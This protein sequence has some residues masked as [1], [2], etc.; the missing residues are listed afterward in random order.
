MIPSGNAVIIRR[1]IVLICISLSIIFVLAG[2][3]VRYLLAPALPVPD[4]REA[5]AVIDFTIGHSVFLV[6][7]KIFSLPFGAHAGGM[8]CL[9]ALAGL[10]LHALLKNKMWKP[11]AN[12]SIKRLFLWGLVF[13][14]LAYG[15][16][17][18]WIPSVPSAVPAD[19]FACIGSLHA[20]RYVNIALYMLNHNA[21]PALQ[22]NI[23][24][25]L[26][27]VIPSIMGFDHLFFSLQ[28]WL[29]ISLA[30]LAL[31]LFG[32]FRDF[33][34]K[35][36]FLFMGVA[37]VFLGNTALYPYH[38]LNIDSGSPFIINGY[39]DSI[40]SLTSL[41][42]VVWLLLKAMAAPP[43]SASAS[44]KSGMLFGIIGAAW[45]LYAPQNVL[46]MLVAF[47]FFFFLY[48]AKK[49]D[50]DEFKT[51]AVFVLSLILAA[52]LAIKAGFGG[53]LAPPSLVDKP[54]IAGLLDMRDRG[55][56]FLPIFPFQRWT[57]DQWKFS[58][59]FMSPENFEF[60]RQIGGDAMKGNFSAF[61]GKAFRLMLGTFAQGIWATF[62]A[63]FGFLGAL[64]AS[65]RK[66]LLEKRF[67]QTTAL[68]FLAGWVVCYAFEISGL[69]WEITRFIIPGYALGLVALAYT[70]DWLVGRAR[71]KKTLAVLCALVGFYIISGPT[72]HIY[73]RD[74]LTSEGPMRARIIKI[75]NLPNSP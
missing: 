65:G 32:F 53:M 29:I 49:M 4:A 38:V 30:A 6:L 5:R 72:Y 7:F 64:L 73:L 45:N 18:I 20:G 60:L 50:K 44:V 54:D 17:Y 1:M 70:F 19:P 42:V 11:H 9:L 13:F 15:S 25:S 57:H 16:A 23:G 27:A 2:S 62:F 61:D 12:G 3:S 66:N 75:M 71:L 56:L 48:M 63:L 37:F 47:G 22:Q 55:L 14:A 36:S 28:I 39:S 59:T 52:A 35:R 74:G 8:V 24:Q 58:A 68:F 43:L 67:W 26:L 46:L 40:L 69:K 10:G 51:S 31:C 21:I 34:I 41:V 33:F